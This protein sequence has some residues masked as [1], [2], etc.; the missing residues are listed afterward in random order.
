MNTKELIENLNTRSYWDCRTFSK[1]WDKSTVLD[2][3]Y[4]SV[5]NGEDHA[6]YVLAKKC[7]DYEIESDLVVYRG[8]NYRKNMGLSQNEMFDMGY[9]KEIFEKYR[10]YYTCSIV[11]CGKSAICKLPLDLF[12]ILKTF[13]PE[14]NF[15][16]EYGCKKLFWKNE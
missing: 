9:F 1:N 11:L 12:S 5:K 13:L 4:E 8:L 10:K 14:Y 3:L 15:L 16:P 7:Q 6:W 2:V